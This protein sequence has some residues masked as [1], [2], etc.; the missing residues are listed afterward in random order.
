MQTR[1]AKLI[2]DRG[3]CSRRKAEGLISQGI[4]FANGAKVLSPAEKFSEDSDILIDGKK[5][6]VRQDA[7]KIWMYYKPVG[8][9]T[10]HDDP[11]NRPTVFDNLPIKFNKKIISIGRLDI[12]SEGLL[13]LTDSGEVARHFELP[14][15]NIERSYKVRAFGK[16]NNQ[17]LNEIENGIEIDGVKYRP[18]KVL[19]TSS[20]GSN[21]WFDITLTEGKNREIRRIFNYFGLEVSKLIRISYGP[22]KLGNLKPGE[23]VEV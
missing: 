16:F 20:Q 5:I 1:I 19:R 4:V 12:N 15:S 14:S 18:A 10:T 6:P 8:L 17:M 2:S 3:H 9:I 7:P 23:M 22:Y 21:N 11:Q 13:L